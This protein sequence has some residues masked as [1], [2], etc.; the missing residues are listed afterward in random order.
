V[1]GFVDPNGNLISNYVE[2]EDVEDVA[3]NKTAFLGRVISLTKD[4]NGN[5]IQFE[6]FVTEEAPDTQAAITIPAA[7]LD[8]VV[9]VNLFPATAYQHSSRPT[10][11]ANLPFDA[12]ALTPGQQVVVHGVFSQP[13]GPPAPAPQPLLNV[14][15][16]KVYDR[17]DA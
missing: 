11:F 15:A 12:S 3:N 16:N 13:P 7:P 6:L 2:I 10:N 9:V 17:L 4:A 1:E 14:A 5:V 8:S